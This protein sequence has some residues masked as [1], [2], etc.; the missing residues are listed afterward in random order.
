[1]FWRCVGTIGREES[2]HGPDHKPS[3]NTFIFTTRGGRRRVVFFWF[4]NPP[5]AT[6]DGGRNAR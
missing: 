1:M 3:R 4:T 6:L 2:N 5:R